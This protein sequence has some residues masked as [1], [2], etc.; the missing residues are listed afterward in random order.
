VNLYPAA[1]DS[2]FAPTG[3]A[4]LTTPGLD[5]FYASTDINGRAAFAVEGRCFVVIGTSFLEVTSTHSATL[6]GTVAQDGNPATISYN[7]ASGG[8][9]FITSGTNGYCYN[10]SSHA[11][12]TELTGTATQGGML[13]TRFLAF[14]VATGRVA[15]SALND[16][17]SWDPTDRW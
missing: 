10:M 12:T 7:G 16:G 9:L 13:N 17:T 11:F 2:Q 15:F 5:T 1:V 3:Q 14:N 8:Q 6:R 4:L